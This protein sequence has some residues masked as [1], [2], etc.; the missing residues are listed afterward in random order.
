MV[1]ERRVLP[2]LIPGVGA[3]E[4]SGVGDGRSR[5]SELM[6]VTAR[7]SALN[8]LSVF[9]WLTGIPPDRYDTPALNLLHATI[10][11]WS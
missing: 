9:D 1:L 2:K 5:R 10:P 11:T 7:T 8:A 3:I 6:H 4:A